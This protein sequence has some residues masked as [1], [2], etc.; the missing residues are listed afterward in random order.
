MEPDLMEIIER[1]EKKGLCFA[2]VEQLSCESFEIAVPVLVYGA[3]VGKVVERGGREDE[4]L[5]I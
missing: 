5:V 1:S 2:A 3:V 4:G